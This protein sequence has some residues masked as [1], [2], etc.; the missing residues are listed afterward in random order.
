[1]FQLICPQCGQKLNSNANC[2]ECGAKLNTSVSVISSS[3]P[4]DPKPKSG[5]L[6]KILESFFTFGQ[7]TLGAILIPTLILFSLFQCF[8]YFNFYKAAYTMQAS[9]LAY[10]YR[11]NPEAADKK[12][13]KRIIM[14]SGEVLEKGRFNDGDIFI[15]LYKEGNVYVHVAFPP[16]EW[17]KII[18]LKEGDHVEI[19]SICGGLVPQQDLNMIDIQLRAVREK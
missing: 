12:Y 19:R 16:D 15:R 18:N 7:T 11:I 14:L 6:W 3:E 10:E 9:D 4:T 1:V 8:L 13:H 17:S 2:N 5:F